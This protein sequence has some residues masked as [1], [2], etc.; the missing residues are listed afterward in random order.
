MD[1]PLSII[2]QLTEI[3]SNLSISLPVIGLLVAAVAVFLGLRRRGS[4]ADSRRQPAPGRDVPLDQPDAGGIVQPEIHDHTG[5]S[6]I[7]DDDSTV[8]VNLPD[9]STVVR[10]AP[11][12]VD[13]DDIEDVVAIQPA[14]TDVTRLPDDPERKPAEPGIPLDELIGMMEDQERTDRNGQ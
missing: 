10:P 7:L 1:T 5:D 13:D 3:L 11:E 6:G 9:G 14:V 2:T 4:G 8:H 12:G